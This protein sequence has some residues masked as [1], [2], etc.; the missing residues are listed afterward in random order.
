MLSIG[1]YLTLTL[2]A[3]LLAGC[4]TQGA[5][6]SYSAGWPMDADGQRF[7]EQSLQLPTTAIISRGLTW[8]DTLQ[9]V[10]RYLQQRVARGVPEE[11]RDIL[12]SRIEQ[13]LVNHPV[14]SVRVTRNRNGIVDHY[15]KLQG[16]DNGSGVR[17]LLDTSPRSVAE[18]HAYVARIRDMRLVAEAS[19]D[20]RLDEALGALEAKS[21]R[22]LELVHEAGLI[23]N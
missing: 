8:E 23:R 16:N 18:A 9:R 20:P 5:L 11:P 4:A 2:A 7:Y 13:A 6:G 10:G 14:S 19:G 22:F 1:K 3:G 15:F 12:R 21:E 17:G